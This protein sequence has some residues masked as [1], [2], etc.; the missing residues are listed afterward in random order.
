M[1]AR[2]SLLASFEAWASFLASRSSEIS[3]KA[4]KTPS[5]FPA[6]NRD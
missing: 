4:L 6:L 3:V 5:N 2:N 1:L